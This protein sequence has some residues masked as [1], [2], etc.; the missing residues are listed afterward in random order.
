MIALLWFLA[1]NAALLILG[2]SAEFGARWWLHRQG[3]YYVWPPGL[4]L[5]LHP[6]PE[7]FPELEPL[8][9]IEINCDGERGDEVPASAENLY[10]IL[11]AGGSAVEGVLLDQPTSWPGALQRLLEL[12]E[13]LRILRASRAHVG[14]I[15]RSGIDSLALD[16]IFE[17]VLPRY[18]HLNA[19]V[20]MVGGSDIL[21]WLAKGEPSSFHPSPLPESE[22]FSCHP[23]GPFGWKPR[24]LALLEF[25]KRL[26]WRWLRPVRIREHAGKWVGN[27]RAMRAQAKEVRTSVSDPAA[28]LDHFE[29]H[30]RKLLQKAKAYADRVLVVQ[31][32]WFEKDYTPKELAH[33]WHGGVGD[34]QREEVAIFY[35]YQ[36]VCRLMALMNTRAVRV[37][38]DLGVECLDLMPLLEPSLKTYYDFFHFAPAGAAAVATA[39]AAVLLRPVPYGKPRW[40]RGMGAPVL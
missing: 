35:S 15:G 36:E 24:E 9:R 25:V 34:P 14:N 29:D 27:A 7:V 3:L 37:A 13:N 39:V 5:Y 6:D 16:L 28:M 20:I 2:V 31:Q 11:A 4:R 17:R 23:E 38:D 33:F 12:P 18:R 8:A 30:F 26:Q 40:S 22:V 1:A 32:P 10:R 21:Q 19:I